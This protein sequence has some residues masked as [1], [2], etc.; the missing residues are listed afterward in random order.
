MTDRANLPMPQIGQTTVSLNQRY[1]T[2]NPSVDLTNKTSVHF[3][4]GGF[5]DETFAFQNA[6]QLTATA[7]GHQSL[8]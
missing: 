4:H 5:S 7:L 3:L 1:F 8:T 2:D 6:T